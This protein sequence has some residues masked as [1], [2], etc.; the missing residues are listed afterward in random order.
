MYDFTT[1]K[2]RRLNGASKW[3]G[4]NRTFV[5]SGYGICE[6]AGNCGGNA[7]LR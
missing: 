4:M 3:T 1:V 5:G 6:C 2:N 7:S